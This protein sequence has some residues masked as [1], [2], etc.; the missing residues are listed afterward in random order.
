MNDGE[1]NNN[2]NR[3][4]ISISIPYIPLIHPLAL[5]L[6]YFWFIV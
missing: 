2:I 1:C 6:F 5:K 3:I 4:V